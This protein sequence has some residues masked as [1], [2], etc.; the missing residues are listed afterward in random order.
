MLVRTDYQKYSNAQEMLMLNFSRDWE[1]PALYFI[2]GAAL[3]NAQERRLGSQEAFCC[4]SAVK[5]IKDEL[6]CFKAG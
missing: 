4:L 1:E 3:R 2:P 5:R 6:S